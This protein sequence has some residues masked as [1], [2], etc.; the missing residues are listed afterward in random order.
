ML[1]MAL[2]IAGLIGWKAR[3]LQCDADMAAFKQAIADKAEDQREQK[4]EIEQKNQAAT[5]QS[6]QRIDQQ[7]DAQQKETVYV[8]KQVIQ[9][10]DRWR[11]RTCSRPVDWVQLYNRSLFGPG[12]PVP[13][14]R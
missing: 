14:T 12:N 8:E 10:R 11:D 9:Y 7:Q 3:G 4:A 6:T 5:E 2:L 1:L 13:E